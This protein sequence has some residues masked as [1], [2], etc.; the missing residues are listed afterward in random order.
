MTLEQFILE[1]TEKGLNVDAL[2]LEKVYN[3]LNTNK[4]E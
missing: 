1:S 3:N 2:T 4:N